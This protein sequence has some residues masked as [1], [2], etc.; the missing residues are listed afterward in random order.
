MHIHFHGVPLGAQLVFAIV[1]FKMLLLSQDVV[2]DFAMAKRSSPTCF[3]FSLLNSDC[4][5]RVVGTFPHFF[6]VTIMYLASFAERNEQAI[7]KAEVATHKRP[8]WRLTTS[9]RLWNSK[10]CTFAI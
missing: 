2:R 3:D 4:P 5:K 7:H 8:K 9:N 10:W 6:E 1:D